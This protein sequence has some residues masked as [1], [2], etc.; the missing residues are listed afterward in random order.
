MLLSFEKRDLKFD[1]LLIFARKF[2]VDVQEYFTFQSSLENSAH[3]HYLLAQY[4]DHLLFPMKKNTW[5]QISILCIVA[6][7]VTALHSTF[8]IVSCRWRFGSNYVTGPASHFLHHHMQMEGW[9]HSNVLK[10]SMDLNS[11]LQ[12]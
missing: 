6:D 3:W 8:Y 11:K 10:D 1:V 4:L 12:P 5:E 7:Y 9:K 2:F